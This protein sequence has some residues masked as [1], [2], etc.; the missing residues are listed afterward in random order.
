MN[1]IVSDHAYQIECLLNSDVESLLDE[2]ADIAVDVL[3]NLPQVLQ[4]LLQGYPK[5]GGGSARR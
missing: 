5:E 4:K 3:A 1:G 2:R